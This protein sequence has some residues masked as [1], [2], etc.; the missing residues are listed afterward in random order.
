MV[1]FSSS[2]NVICKG[3]IKRIYKWDHFA[4]ISILTDN[5]GAR[6]ISMPTKS[7]EAMALMAF[8]SGKS[9]TLNLTYM[10]P[11][12]SSKHNDFFSSF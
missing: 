4:I 7:D 9:I 11:L 3:K 6:W 1:C 10:N 12:R 5:V 2:A 8:A